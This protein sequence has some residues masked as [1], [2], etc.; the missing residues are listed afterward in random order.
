[1]SQAYAIPE[2][3]DYPVFIGN[4]QIEFK[5][6]KVPEP[7]P[8]QLLIQCKANALCASDLP[9]LANG[10]DISI[11]HENAGIVVKGGEGTTTEISTKGVVFLMG[12][13][14]DCRSC[15]L[16]LTNQC[17][18]KRAD[19][20]FTHDGGYAPYSVINENVFFP[21]DD[22]VDLAEAT[23]L[24]DI[25]GT[26]HHS[27]KRAN[28]FHPDPQSLLVMGAGPIGLG[29]A[30]MAKLTYGKDFPVYIADMIDYRLQL[31]EKLGAV[32]IQLNDHSL[33]EFFAEHNVDGVD[34]VIDSTG[35]TVARQS[36][37]QCLNQRGVFVC[38]GHGE[39]IT[40]DISADMVANE[41]AVIG[42]EYF[43]YNEMAENYEL[44]RKHRDYL[45][46]VITHRYPISEIKEAFAK[47]NGRDTGK[48]I[49][50]Q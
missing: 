29:I 2:T 42:S 14:G 4:N 20:G 26:G 19:Y 12:Y 21:V 38:V 25:M 39:Q 45:K 28:Q 11:G 40:L 22:D 44:F 8:G 1:M 27:I 17:L 50:E 6:R 7:G 43:Q 5:Q 46:Q 3:A 47:F 32:S 33:K 18:D 31:A 24:L 16:G 49:I 13:C 37:F 36:S 34:I 30:A 23:L 15:N 9:D 10:A 48:V 35:K 41:R